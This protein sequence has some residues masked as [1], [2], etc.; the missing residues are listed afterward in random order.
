MNVRTIKSVNNQVADSRINFP[1]N[2]IIR[3][4]PKDPAYTAR[5]EPSDTVAYGKYLLIAA[6]CDD[7][8]TDRVDGRQQGETLAGGREFLFPEIGI[9]RSANLTPDPET[10]LGDWSRKDF[11]ERFKSFDRVAVASIIVETGEA[12]TV[13]PWWEFSG[14]ARE[15]LGAIYDYLRTLKP[16]N[17]EIVPFEALSN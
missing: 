12:N 13:M 5:P 10:G 16:E 7:C 3:T 2:W 6:A 4:V 9:M 11:I 1:L 8:H 15:D 14:M 17:S